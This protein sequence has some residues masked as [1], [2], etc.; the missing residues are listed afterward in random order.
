[1]TADPGREALAREQADRIAALLDDVRRMASPPE[2]QRVEE[3]VQRLV[4]LYGKGIERLLELIDEAGALDE[5]MEDLLCAD[6]LVS[7]LLALHGLHPASADARLRA[8]LSRAA[9]YLEPHGAAVELVGM[10]TEGVVRLRLRAGRGACAST[11]AAIEGAIRACV[12][13]AVPEVR[14]IEVDGGDAH[15]PRLVQIDVRR[16]HATAREEPR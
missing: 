15:A 8:A 16:S 3:L 4:G 9:P 14:R 10:D 12:E 1:M 13:A 7:S 11:Q 6:E 2:R 5:R